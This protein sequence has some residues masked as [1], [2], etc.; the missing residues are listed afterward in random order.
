MEISPQSLKYLE[1]ELFES[2]SR[3]LQIA[4]SAAD[5]LFMALAGIDTVKLLELYSAT[6]AQ[7]NPSAT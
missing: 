7:E 5:S 4:T 2:Q 6:V 3:I 1:R